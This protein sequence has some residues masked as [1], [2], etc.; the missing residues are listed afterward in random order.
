MPGAE[1]AYIQDYNKDGLPDIWVLFAQG[2]EGIFLFTNKGKV[3]DR[4]TYVMIRRYG[5]LIVKLIIGAIVAAKDK[6]A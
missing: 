1:K 2:D 3:I 4:K 6:L 5:A